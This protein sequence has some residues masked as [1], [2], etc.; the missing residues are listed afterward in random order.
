MCIS[1]ARARDFQWLF[2]LADHGRE[3]CHWVVPTLLVPVAASR[4]SNL[5]RSIATLFGVAI[6]P[7]RYYTSWHR[8]SCS[9]RRCGGRFRVR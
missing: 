9:G 2:L 4:T 3:R 1:H 6:A 7:R 5:H 8:R